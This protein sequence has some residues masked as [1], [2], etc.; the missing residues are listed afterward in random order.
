MNKKIPLLI[1]AVIAA[2]DLI[3]HTIQLLNL[4]GDFIVNLYAILTYP[5]RFIDYDLFWSLIWAT[6]FLLMVYEIKKA[7]SG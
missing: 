3:I 4:G 1:T 7:G 5:Q 2:Y 6:I